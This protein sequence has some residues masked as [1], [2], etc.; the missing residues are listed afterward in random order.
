VVVLESALGTAVINIFLFVMPVV[1]GLS[2]I[3]YYFIERPFLK[4]RKDY[5][6]ERTDT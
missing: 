6:Q 5:I 4:R 2:S 1:I 3:T